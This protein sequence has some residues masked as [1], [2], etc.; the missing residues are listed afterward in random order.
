MKSQ[1]KILQLK[2]KIE[3]SLCGI[4]G[5]NCI[6][7]DV[8][9]YHNIGDVLI[10]KGETAFLAEHGKRCLYMAS[11]ETCTYPKVEKGTT[12]LFNGGGN[13]GDMYH[14]HMD[15]L[16]KVCRHYSGN[17]VVVFPQTVYYENK[18]RMERDFSIL[19]EHKDLYFCARDSVSFNLLHEYFGDMVLLL[20][21]MAFCINNEDL[22]RYVLKETKPKLIIERRDC[23]SLACRHMPS[24]MPEVEISDWPTFEKSFHSTTFLNKI[25]KKI[26]DANVPLVTKASNLFWNRYFVH[27]FSELMFKEGIR[28]ISPY[29]S[30]ETTRLH[31]CIL[32][33]LLGKEV[34]LIDNSYGKNSNFYDTWLQD[35]DN[36]TLKSRC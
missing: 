30:I 9:Y 8:P 31:G 21:D 19:H 33:I 32:S 5:R 2:T 28:F 36:V 7:L 4:I 26:A 16:Q 18:S 35:L 14:E 1:E 6:L 13:L 24:V 22:Q 10:W 27:C 17:R 34:V 25:F 29:H 23:E 12:V 3:K 20:P 11:Y 15:F